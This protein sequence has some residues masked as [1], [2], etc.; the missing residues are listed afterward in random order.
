M[1]FDTHAHYDDEAFDGD[2]EEV[3]SSMR[4]NNVGCIVNV[5]ASLKGVKESVALS[6]RY[7]FIYAAAGI[8]PDEAGSMSGEVLEFLHSQCM[9]EKTVAVG[10]IGLDYHWDVEPRE[11]QQK[12]FIEQLHLAKEV[13]LPV[14][15]HS[16]EAAR[17]TFDIMKREHAGST[18]GV[19]HCFSGSL[20]MAREYV[21]MGYYIGIGGVVTFKNSR[22]L[23]QI[24]M[25]IPLEYLV[26]E[27]DSPYLAPEPFRG[28]R[29]DSRNLSYVLE[30]IARIKGLTVQRVE[31]I[32]Y[33]NAKNLYRL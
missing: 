28:E 19:I 2:R 13:D 6:S 20:E 10:E 5:G 12:W 17:D 33:E 32:V 21:R 9:L 31:D 4:D 11:D 1:I 14:N 16:R 26:T 27:T 23:K 7:S 24:V 3:L 18:G 22:M 25:D 30:E 15:I 8:H 29:N